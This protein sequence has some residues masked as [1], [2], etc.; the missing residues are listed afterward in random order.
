[1]ATHLLQPDAVAL[2]HA[3]AFGMQ[4]EVVDGLVRR[5]GQNLGETTAHLDGILL[6]GFVDLQ[7]N[8]AGGRSIDEAVRA[9]DALDVVARSIGQH[10]AAAFLPTLISQRFDDLLEP[11]A[12]VAKWIE[13]APCEGAEPLGLHVEGPFLK[14]PGAHA[15]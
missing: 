12:A 14:V 5:V 3:I 9:P 1:M 4:V 13:S 10:G 15:A 7:V 8:G 11:I 2:D 6:P